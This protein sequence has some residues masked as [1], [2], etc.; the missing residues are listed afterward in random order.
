MTWAEFLAQTLNNVALVGPLLD[1]A[2]PLVMPTVFVDGGADFLRASVAMSPREVPVVS[3]GDGD[4]SS[5]P[6]DEKL[7]REKDFSDLAFAL[8]G[9][10]AAVSGLELFGFLGG[11]RDHELANIGE[12]H[13]FLAARP[14]AVANF[15]GPQKIEVIAFTGHLEI[16]IHGTFSVFVLEA[17]QVEI[18][19]ACEYSHHGEVL[20]LS[21]LGLS[22]VGKGK[23]SLHSPRPVFIFLN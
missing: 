5:V 6:L 8:R 10:P 7:A 12:V 21:S 4:S 11:R 14:S 3:L 17:A 23:V 20:P 18:N 19:G 1:R 2:R 13:N 9:L 16:E 22:N 15:H